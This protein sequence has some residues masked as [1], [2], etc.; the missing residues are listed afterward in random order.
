MSSKNTLD[1]ACPSIVYPIYHNTM[2]AKFG[3]VNGILL[4]CNSTKSYQHFLAK[5][6][7]YHYLIISI[8]L[9]H[10]IALSAD[11][12]S[13][14]EG[15]FENNTACQFYTQLSQSVYSLHITNNK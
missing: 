6:D 1:G 12:F 10:T 7:I 8:V 4:L 15:F 3:V 9:S 2:S 13:L 14:Q 11:S 5:T